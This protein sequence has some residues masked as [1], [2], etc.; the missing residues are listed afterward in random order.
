MTNDFK[1]L[2]GQLAMG[3]NFDENA[4]IMATQIDNGNKNTEVNAYIN[5]QKNHVRALIIEII[6]EYLSGFDD[7]EVS[8]ECEALMTSFTHADES[9]VQPDNGVNLAL[10][11]AMKSDRNRIQEI[12]DIL[13]EQVRE[14]FESEEK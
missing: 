13:A 14:I 3:M 12:V 4:V 10:K 6:K 9:N 11:T 2:A 5:G 1:R 8:F 7:K